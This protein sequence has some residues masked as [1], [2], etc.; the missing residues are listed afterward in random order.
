MPG[1]YNQYVKSKHYK[2]GVTCFD[3]HAAQKEDADA[4]MHND[5]RISVIVTPKDCSKC[6]QSQVTEFNMSDHRNARILSTE[7]SGGIFADNLVNSQYPLPMDNKSDRTAGSTTA[8]RRCHGSKIK[9]DPA[10]KGRPT[11]DTWPNSGIARENPDGSIGNCAACHEGHEFSMAQAR[12]PESCAVCHNSGGGDPQY[13]AYL[14]SRHGMR[15]YAL[16]D[17]MYLDSGSWVAGK[18][19][20][21]APTCTTCHISAAPG[22]KATHNINTRLDWDPFLQGTNS[23]AINEKCGEIFQTDYE[24]PPPD[25]EHWENM[26]MVCLACHSN[27]FV[28]NFKKQYRDEVLLF[29]TKWLDPGKKL[30]QQAVDVIQKMN[31]TE[32]KTYAIFTH[33][34]DY[35]WWGICVDNAMSAKTG[36]A[37]M[38]AG[39]VEIGAGGAAANW[40]TGLMPSVEGVI[41]EAKKKKH[42]SEELIAALRI[43]TETYNKI[44]SDPVYYGPWKK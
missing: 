15:Y 30:F 24:Q 11:S 20:S 37:M 33:P 5:Q 14:Q 25:P 10:K 38:S 18:D 13:K 31:G 16:E 29:K 34:M 6:H 7:G 2:V 1:M 23:L 42:K 39:S 44:T 19:Y 36:A 26:K 40:Y 22:L 32:D 4:F 43:L 21:A 3:C 35:A 8:C 12:K 9:M 27:S 17:Q 41:E 28:E